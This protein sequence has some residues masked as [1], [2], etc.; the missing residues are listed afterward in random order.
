MFRSLLNSLWLSDHSL[1]HRFQHITFVHVW[2]SDYSLSHR[3]QHITFVRV[4]LSDHSLSHR[5]QHI[6]FVRVWLSDH[7]L[8]HRFQ[9]ITFVRVWLSDHSLSHRFQH[10]TCSSI[11]LQLRQFELGAQNVCIICIECYCSY[12]LTFSCYAHVH[13][14]ELSVLI[15]LFVELSV[16]DVMATLD[17]NCLQ[18]VY[19]V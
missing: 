2:L 16:V 9:H 3:F 10:I 8:S 11:T 13:K 15:V 14:K 4:W 19:I 17:L 6:T 12:D 5:F 1:S 18:H 7:S